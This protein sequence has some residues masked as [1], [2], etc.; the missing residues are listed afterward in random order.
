M[1]AAS[2]VLSEAHAG[3]VVALYALRDTLLADLCATLASPSQGLAQAAREAKRQHT[4]SGGAAAKLVKIDFAYNLVRHLTNERCSTYIQEIRQMV[5]QS[6]SA[7]APGQVAALPLADPRA[8]P[9]ADSAAHSGHGEHT[10]SEPATVHEAE[11]RQTQVGVKALIAKFESDVP[12]VHPNQAVDHSLE[13]PADDAAHSGPYDHL[14]ESHDH[15]LESDVPLVHPNQAVDA[16][17]S[18]PY[19]HLA[20]SHDHCLDAPADDGPQAAGK[21]EAVPLTANLDQ[22]PDALSHI[23]QF[24]AQS[25][26]QPIRPIEPAAAPVFLDFESLDGMSAESIAEAYLSAARRSLA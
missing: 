11:L 2:S 16:A 7:A 1:S 4:I 9:Q 19:D 10:M 14:A 18:G 6:R 15:S 8:G 5:T 22:F 13:A 21:H 17:H 20:E 3:K 12:V 25:I 26:F 23:R 24:Q